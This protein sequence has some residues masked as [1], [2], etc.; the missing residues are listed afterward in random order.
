MGNTST[1]KGC[2]ARPHSWLARL[3]KRMSGAVSKQPST[4]PPTSPD[5][6]PEVADCL[7]E[8]DKG[9][10]SVQRAWEGGVLGSKVNPGRVARVLDALA[11]REPQAIAALVV[12]IASPDNA[13]S[14]VTT[15][16]SVNNPMREQ[17]VRGVMG[18]VLAAIVE[19]ETAYDSRTPTG[20]ALLARM[21]RWLGDP[22]SRQEAGER[23]LNP[24]LLSDAND[25][26]CRIAEDVQLS[27]E[28]SA[29]AAACARLGIVGPISVALQLVDVQ[30]SAGRAT[31]DASSQPEGSPGS[32]RAS[33]AVGA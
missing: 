26:L 15:L 27:F 29:R 14:P 2:E 9:V 19:V 25:T 16:T 33:Q 7:A 24:V 4:T 18:A 28:G 20:A 30:E 10:R 22:T 3:R 1:H 23:T 13:V 8:F 21:R 5:S 31:R 6:V 12:E 32:T 17:F 11:S